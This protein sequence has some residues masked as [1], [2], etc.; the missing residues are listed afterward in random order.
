VYKALLTVGFMKYPA[1]IPG[2][3]HEVFAAKQRVHLCTISCFYIHVVSN[4]SIVKIQ[5]YLDI[6]HDATK[7]QTGLNQTLLFCVQCTCVHCCDRV[8]S[9]NIDL[10]SSGLFQ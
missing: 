5:I 7:M 2:A 4:F 9:R 8:S 10:P 6:K 3:K 1:E